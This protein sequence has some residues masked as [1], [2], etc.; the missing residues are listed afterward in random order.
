MTFENRR[1]A[2][3]KSSP[4]MAIA[5]AARKLAAEGR[6]IIDL[7]LG[8]PDFEPPAH[9]CEAACAAIRAGGIRYGVPAGT[10]ALRR[11]IV[12]KFKAENGLDYSIDEVMVA[13]GA[14]QILFDVFLATLEPGDEVII[15]TPCW[16]SYGDIVSLHGG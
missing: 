4:S 1:A 10:E 13:N 14:K 16:V 3:I 11:A 6:D 5:M 9:V 8:E 15:P 12:E 7:S 2:G